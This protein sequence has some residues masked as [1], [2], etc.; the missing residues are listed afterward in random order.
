MDAKNPFIYIRR[1]YDPVNIIYITDDREYL[2][3][4]SGQQ[5]LFVGFRGSG[6]TSILRSMEWDVVWRVGDIRIEGSTAVKKI[7]AGPPKHLGVRWRM[8]DMD[9]D[10]WDRWR[11]Q[12][13]VEWAQK[14]F[15][16]YVE[17]VLLELFTSALVRIMRSCPEHFTNRQSEKRL[18]VELMHTAFSGDTKFRPK[19][20]EE[21][22]WALRTVFRNH[23]FGIRDLVYRR[24]CQ[25]A[26]RASYPVLS[27]GELVQC[28]AQ[29]LTGLYEN[30][31]ELKIFP[32][33]DD[34]NHLV[35]W[36]AQVVN[37][38]ISRAQS[39]VAYK[40]TSVSGLYSSQKTTDGRPLSE[41]ELKTIEISAIEGKWKF[42]E[43]FTKLVQG[44]CRTRIAKYYGDDL[45]EKFDLKLF[46]GDFDLE[47]AL[48]KKLSGS[49]RREAIE[50]LEAA[51]RNAK[52][53]RKTIPVTFTW[54]SRQRV[55]EKQEPSSENPQIHKKLLR[56][57]YTQYFKKWNHAAAIA[58]C[59]DPVL[60]L[61][62]P[63]YGWRTVIH[64][65]SG[66]LRGV[67]C[68]MS[69]I[70]SDLKLPADKFVKQRGIRYDKQTKAIKQAVLR[71]FHSLDKKP[72]FE[73][74][75]ERLASSGPPGEQ[76]LP[77]SLPS[78]CQRLG[79]LFG[80]FQS[81][82]S[83]C[84][85]A[86]TASLTVRKDHLPEDISQ[87]VD[88]AVMTGVML[89]KDNPTT[90]TVGLHPFLSPLFNISFRYP[91]YYP[92]TVNVK[93]FIAIFRGDDKEAK[94]ASR[95]ILDGRMTRYSQRGKAAKTAQ[96]QKGQMDLLDNSK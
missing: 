33:L 28:F 94:E 44:V 73:L 43:K 52:D 5:C 89:K 54:L 38:A 39:P 18:L 80:E 50:L 13:G 42:H 91:F 51:K 7:F 16:T 14:Y 92:E 21:S 65:G 29:S 55:R 67:L 46:L 48:V 78:I 75:A 8:E 37:S 88:F 79:T 68:I 69:E 1:E 93:D 34:C 53:R 87:A 45:A 11:R 96:Q 57:L 76:Y 20:A 60:R 2:D 71:Y 22:L 32:M 85:N 62:F 23:R 58:I 86:E 30:F 6:K 95:R 10:Y 27:P 40:I 4:I 77:T 26:M 24:S 90:L 70:W 12:V 61:S 64:L 35:D 63:Y 56:R 74:K 81:Y 41:Q 66:S 31:S 19:L 83:V 3:W 59:R 36:Q 72:I 49:E 82:P 15:G 84:V 17:Y 9:K 25:D 47:D